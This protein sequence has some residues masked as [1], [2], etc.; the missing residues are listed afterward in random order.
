[1][2][3]P[4][5]VNLN[6]FQ[7]RFPVMAIVSILHRITGVI[8][9]LAIPLLLYILNASLLNAQSYDQTVQFCHSGL[10]RLAL[11]AILVSV[12]YHLLAGVRHIVMDFGV[13]E[14]LP[15]AKL[16]AFFVIAA[17]LILAAL[18]GVWIW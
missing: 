13:G 16:S 18:S 7:I 6:L 12:I 1:M 3:S 10:C 2:K 5:P 17:T 4:R 8:T 14:S 9:F 15:P 11:W